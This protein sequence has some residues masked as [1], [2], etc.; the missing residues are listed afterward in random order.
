M[1]ATAA[2]TATTT[3]ANDVNK[4]PRPTVTMDPMVLINKMDQ[5]RKAAPHQAWLE[6]REAAIAESAPRAHDLLWGYITPDE[7]AAGLALVPDAPKAKLWD[8]AF[9]H[10]VYELLVAAMEVI[11]GCTPKAPVYTVRLESPVWH[12]LREDAVAEAWARAKG[13]LADNNREWMG[14][15]LESGWLSEADL[16]EI[17]AKLRETE[18]IYAMWHSTHGFFERHI[19]SAVIDALEIN[20]KTL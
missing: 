16:A 2:T 1:I 15:K 17:F 20:V 9:H 4:R 11:R 13:A 6:A 3:P 18:F 12:A 7:F 5:L 19:E 8:S 10:M 14:D